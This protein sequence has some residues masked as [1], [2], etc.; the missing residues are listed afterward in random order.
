MPYR[1]AGI[2]M[3]KTVLAVVGSDVEVDAEYRFERRMFGSDPEQLRSVA[4]ISA[5]P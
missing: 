1:I 3:H 4:G 5:S 2:N